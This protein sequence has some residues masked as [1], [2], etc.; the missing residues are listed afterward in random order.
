MEL[1]MI[2]VA[3][4]VCMWYML[5]ELYSIRKLNEE[6]VNL[7]KEQVTELR[8]FRSAVMIHVGGDN[9]NGARGAIWEPYD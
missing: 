7:Y 5:S 4:L 6:M 3:M 8:V 1:T 2:V 9:E